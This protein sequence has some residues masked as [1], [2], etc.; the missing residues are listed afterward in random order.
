[1]YIGLFDDGYPLIL[2]SQYHLSSHSSR[3]GDDNPFP[4][5]YRSHTSYIRRDEGLNEKRQ[6]IYANEGEVTRKIDLDTVKL[7]KVWNKIKA[8]YK[9]RYVAEQEPIDER[10]FVDR[11]GKKMPPNLKTFLKHQNLNGPF[12]NLYMMSSKAYRQQK[13]FNDMHLEQLNDSIYFDSTKRVL[14][15]AVTPEWYMIYEDNRYFYAMDMLPDENGYVGQ[16]I[17]LGN[18][19]EPNKFIAK[20]L[21]SFLQLYLKEQVP[22]D[23]KGWN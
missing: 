10:I 18:D 19:G 14:P 23:I 2:D 15:V 22:M 4:Q 7:V 8:K 17:L 11:T 1:P 5:F 20:D 6:L 21:V 9:F 3:Y 13:K 16:V 12:L